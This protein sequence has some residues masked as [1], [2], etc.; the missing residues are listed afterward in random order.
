LVDRIFSDVADFGAASPPR[1]DQTVMIVKRLP[2]EPEET[3][4]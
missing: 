2:T 1:D 3:P 4:A